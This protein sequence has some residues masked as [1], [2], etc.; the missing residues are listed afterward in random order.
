VAEGDILVF[1]A[2][3]SIATPAPFVAEKLNVPVRKWPKGTSWFS[4]Q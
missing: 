2:M 4:A 3:I 1:R